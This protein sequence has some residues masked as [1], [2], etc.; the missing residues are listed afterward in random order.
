MTP[1]AGSILLFTAAFSGLAALAHAQAKLPPALAGLQGKAMPAWSMKTVDGK[2]LNN[3]N[4][5]G[6]VVLLDFWATWCGPCRAASPTMQ[7]LHA[8]HNRAGLLVVGANGMENTKGPKPAKDYAAKGK[9]AYTFTY[10]NDKLLDR[11]KIQ[12]VPTFIVIDRRGVVRF[13]AN[14]W[15]PAVK[16][17]LEKAVQ[18]A[19][20]A[21]AR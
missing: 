4:T 18:A 6:R 7:A 8:K 15:T 5:R 1:R 12:G 11:L 17:G 14:E 13:V 16:S 3:A 21:R 19:V 10:D 9:Y 2:T 20:S